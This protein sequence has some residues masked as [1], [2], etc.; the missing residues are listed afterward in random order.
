MN[1]KRQKQPST[2]HGFQHAHKNL[3]NIPLRTCQPKNSHVNDPGHFH[4]FQKDFWAPPKI[5]RGVSVHILPVHE[6]MH[7]YMHTSRQCVGFRQHWL[8]GAMHIHQEPSR[9]DC[10]SHLSS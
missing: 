1:L 9:Y 8:T 3:A 5:S 6:A 4:M 2:Q 7:V 10:G